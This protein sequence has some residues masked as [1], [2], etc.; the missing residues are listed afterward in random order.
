MDV[1]LAARAAGKR[2]RGER[3]FFMHRSMARV[4]GRAALPASERLWWGGCVLQGTDD[5]KSPA[6]MPH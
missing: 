6:D 1:G 3:A 5:L 2:G 4:S